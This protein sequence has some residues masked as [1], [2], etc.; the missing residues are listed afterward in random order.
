MK[1]FPEQRLPQMRVKI[2]EPRWVELKKAAKSWINKCELGNLCR[3]CGQPIKAGERIRKKCHE[4]CYRATL[5][6]VEK[7]Q[8]TI[9]DRVA[10]GKLAADDEVQKS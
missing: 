5:R 3:A 8:T 6:A 10:Q 2:F 7:G 4:R 9:A 1:E